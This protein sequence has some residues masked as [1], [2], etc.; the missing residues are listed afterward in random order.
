MNNRLVKISSASKAAPLAT[1]RRHIVAVLA[2]EILNN[3]ATDAFPIES[4]HQL[5]RRFG[6]SRVTVRLALADLENRA[7]IYR[8]HGTG[9]FAHGRSAR[10]YRHIGVLIKSPLTTENRPLAE[11]LRGV[12]TIMTLLP[13]TIILIGMSGPRLPLDRAEEISI[14][15]PSTTRIESH[16]FFAGQ[17]AA[18]ALNRAFLTGEPITD[19]DKLRRSEADFNITIH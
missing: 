5:C 11:I 9:T 4:E 16:F 14:N 8:K 19:F 12:Q 7:L 1:A 13:A 2:Q 10:T 6:V 18:N 15:H 3:P 17:L